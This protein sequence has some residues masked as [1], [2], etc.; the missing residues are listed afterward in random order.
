MF[1]LIGLGA[2]LAMVFACCSLGGLTSGGGDSP[3]I[4]LPGGN[5]P[6]PG[7]G[8]TEVDLT[9]MGEL[10]DVPIY[11]GAQSAGEKAEL[12]A[13]FGIFLEQFKAGLEKEG[14]GFGL[15]T[16]SDSVSAVTQWYQTQMPVNG[17]TATPGLEQA[18]GSGMLMFERKSDNS[19]LLILTFEDSDTKQTQI[20]LLRGQQK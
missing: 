9:Q 5:L 8:K 12:P 11:P 15:Y 2:M 14:A 10:G 6:I 4:P 18:G 17:W 7:L 20:F 3:G 19:S 1:K 13:L 16:T